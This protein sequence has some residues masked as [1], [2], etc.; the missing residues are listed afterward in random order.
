MPA[1]PV[2]QYG[3]AVMGAAGSYQNG[4]PPFVTAT[5]KTINPTMT[6]MS[7]PLIRVR[8]LSS[9]RRIGGVVNSVGLQR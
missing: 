6:C 2:T 4:D 7:M 5:S 3:E 8:K 1:D 9:T